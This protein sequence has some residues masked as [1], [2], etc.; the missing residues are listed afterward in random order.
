MLELINRY[1]HGFVAIPV[2]L[3]CR[4]QALFELLREP[5]TTR[6]LARR[7]GANEGHLQV[8]LRLLHS[9]SWLECNQ[10]GEY[11]LTERAL[12]AVLPLDRAFPERVGGF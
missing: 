6:G 2:I 9:L 5:N 8:A 12:F 7:L 10:Q 3:A 11:C 1:A 4:E